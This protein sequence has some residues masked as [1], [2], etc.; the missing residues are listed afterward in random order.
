M[1]HP[2]V[3]LPLVFAEVPLANTEQTQTREK[4]EENEDYHT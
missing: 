3:K 4:K 1:S 2:R